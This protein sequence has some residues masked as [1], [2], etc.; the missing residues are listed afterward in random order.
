MYSS[1]GTRKVIRGVLH[2]T[3]T[4]EKKRSVLLQN[5]TETVLLPATPYYGGFLDLKANR[6]RSDSLE[7]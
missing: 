2:I 1:S 5:Q 6:A 7:W 3:R 4:L